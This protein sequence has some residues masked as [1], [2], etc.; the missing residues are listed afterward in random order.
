M[1][2]AKGGA[3]KALPLTYACSRL[4]CSCACSA[5]GKGQSESLAADMPTCRSASKNPARL[6]LRDTVKRGFCTSTWPERPKLFFPPRR[7]ITSIF[8][9]QRFTQ[10]CHPANE[11]RVHRPAASAQPYPQ[12]FLAAWLD[13]SVQREPG[14]YAVAQLLMT[15]LKCSHTARAHPLLLW[16]LDCFMH[17]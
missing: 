7:R 9:Q 3:G 5:F 8:P 14:R 13:Q 16:Q 4:R 15:S 17:E 12:A 10:P 2:V 6:P 1:T 11:A